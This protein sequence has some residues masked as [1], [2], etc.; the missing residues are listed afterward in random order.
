M[1][2]HSSKAPSLMD[3]LYELRARLAAAEAR[4]ERLAGALAP[5]LDSPDAQG[6][7]HFTSNHIPVYIRVTAREIKK[8]RAALADNAEGD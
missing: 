7:H 6:I 3:E 1:I 2:D 5:F 8:A 4:A